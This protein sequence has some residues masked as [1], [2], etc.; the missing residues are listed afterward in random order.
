[1]KNF[2]FFGLKRSGLHCIT[3]DIILNLSKISET[4]S[5]ISVIDK[6]SNFD[7]F[8]NYIS[9]HKLNCKL[10]NYT[11]PNS[12]IIYYN[13]YTYS[14]YYGLKI[15]NFFRKVIK[16]NIYQS[17]YNIFLFEDKINIYYR[18]EI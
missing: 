1:M 12:D 5:N 6:K 9:Q 18:G 14:R 3:Q 17:E 4:P 10:Y 7:N 8:N 16:K 15:L 11:I 13:N 2:Y